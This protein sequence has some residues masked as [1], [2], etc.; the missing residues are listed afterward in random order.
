MY[1]RE[2]DDDPDAADD[3]PSTASPRWVLDSNPQGC[4]YV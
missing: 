4:E 2:D 1:S 3:D